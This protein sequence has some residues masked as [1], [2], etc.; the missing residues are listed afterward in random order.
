MGHGMLS[1]VSLPQDS[2]LRLVV[3]D[4]LKA[5]K[6]LAASV[7]E[8][9]GSVG[10]EGLQ[11]LEKMAGCD[12]DGQEADSAPHQAS[13]QAVPISRDWELLPSAAASA[14]PQSKN[15]GSGHCGPEP[16]SS[17]QRLY[18]EVF[19]GSPGPPTSQVGP[20]SY[21]VTPFCLLFLTIQPFRFV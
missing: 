21:P 8:V 10:W 16:S 5:E 11:F 14:E 20:A 12:L 9:S 7:T 3:G 15:L 1:P 17:G 4:S 2:D 19:Y 6:E 13:S 18:P